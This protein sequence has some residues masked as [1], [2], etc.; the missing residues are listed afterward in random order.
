MSVFRRSEMEES[1]GGYS[2]S[3][4]RKPD[5]PEELTPIFYPSVPFGRC[6]TRTFAYLG[7]PK[8]AAGSEHGFPAVVLVHGGNGKAESEWV[9]QWVARGY[10][11]LAMDLNAQMYTPA[12]YGEFSANPE[13]GPHGYGSFEQMEKKLH[14]TWVYHSVSNAVLARKILAELPCVDPG[15]IGIAGISWGGMITY[16]TAAVCPDFAFC[17]V[18]YTMAY[19]YE[20][21]LW[22]N[23][24]LREDKMGKGFVRWKKYFDPS[25]YIPEI[26][27]PTLLIRG[28]DDI[29]FSTALWNRTVSLFRALLYLSQHRSMVHDQNHGADQREIFAFA[30][31]VVR[32]GP[33]LLRVSPLGRQD[34]TVRFG[35]EGGEA[36]SAELLWSASESENGYEWQWNAL[37]MKRVRGGV[38]EAELPE[39][40]RRFY[41]LVRDERGNQT[42]SVLSAG[43][44]MP[45]G[46]GV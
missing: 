45:S 28:A 1:Y 32:G 13:G 11:A 10:V 35:T 44:E 38:W 8:E 30:D 20:D 16:L 37:P 2:V 14:D 43:R 41:A 3:K 12:A 40:C 26:Q 23:S 33:A 22:Q 5:L 31:S 6:V 29:A 39:G 46:E 18:S 17:S 9:R 42:S 7:I 25:R 34:G 19:L 36:V 27:M 24:G 21:P 15:R 4:V